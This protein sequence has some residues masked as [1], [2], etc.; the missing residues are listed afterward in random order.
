MAKADNFRILLITYL[1]ISLQT[2][3]FLKLILYLLYTQN[4]ICTNPCMDPFGEVN[5]KGLDIY[6]MLE[7]WNDITNDL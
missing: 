7:S 6:P 2:N 3:L 5:L 4:M 1:I